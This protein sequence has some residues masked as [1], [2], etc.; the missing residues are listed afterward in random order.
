MHIQRLAPSHA[1][2][3]LVNSRYP[4][5]CAT[6]QRYA[7]RGVSLMPKARE[8]FAEFLDQDSLDRLGILYLTTSVGLGYGRRVPSRRSFSRRTGSPDPPT[9]GV[10]SRLAH[11]PP[12]FAWG[13]GSN[14]WPWKNHL[15]GRPPVRVTP[16]L[17]ITASTRPSTPHAEPEGT[18]RS[19]SGRASTARPLRSHAG[20]GISTRSSIR[21]RLSASP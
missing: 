21:L 1:P 3:F 6:P 13:A 15:H 11:T 17:A 20:T 4:L 12:G 10:P 2:V 8:R 16:P 5:A 7:P 14:A 19:T 9:K 18:T